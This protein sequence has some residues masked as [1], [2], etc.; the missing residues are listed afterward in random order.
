MGFVHVSHILASVKAGDMIMG[1][2]IP[3]TAKLLRELIHMGQIIQSHS[4]HFFYLAS[5]DLLLGWDADPKIRNIVGVIEKYPDIATKGV[6][7]RKFGQSIIEWVAGARINPK[8]IVPGGMANSL[9]PQI[10][11][12]I[13]S[14]IPKIKS[15]VIFAIDLLKDYIQK[16]HDFINDYANFDSGYLRVN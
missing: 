15:Y 11:D 10:K 12:K 3:Y 1:V 6:E 7:L 13:L 16:N 5:P 8:W 14:H 9:T 2:N 4:L